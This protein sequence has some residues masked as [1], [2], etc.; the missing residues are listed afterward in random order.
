MAQCIKCKTTIPNGI[1]YCENCY[2]LVKNKA[3]ESYLDSLLSS[4]TPSDHAKD[5]YFKHKNQANENVA[6]EEQEDHVNN[7]KKEEIIGKPVPSDYNIFSTSDDDSDMDFLDSLFHSESEKQSQLDILHDVDKKAEDKKAEDKKAENKKAENKKAENKEAD[8]E[9]DK[10]NTEDEALADDSFDYSEILN[11]VEDSLPNIEVTRI[12]EEEAHEE[13]EEKKLEIDRFENDRL[14]NDSYENDNL[15]NM[16]LENKGQKEDL[17]IDALGYKDFDSNVQE[18]NKSEQEDHD[19]E[20]LVEGVLEE[21]NHEQA[22]IEDYDQ[23]NAMD[24]L[25][26]EILPLKDRLEEDNLKK[27]IKQAENNKEEEEPAM[28]ND[29]DYAENDQDL[30]DLINEINNSQELPS[31]DLIY[32]KNVDKKEEKKTSSMD[33]GDVFSDALGAVSS[34]GDVPIND[35]LLKMIPDIEERSTVNT[36][37]DI[38]PNKKKKEKNKQSK[39]AR[40]RVGFWK[41]IFG[42]IKEELTEEEIETRKN[43]VIQEGEQKEEKEKLKQ[44]ELKA[45]KQKEKEEKAE[46]EKQ[47]KELAAKKKAE[48]AAKAKAKKEEKEKRSREIQE[49]I[50]EI[51]ENEGKIN[52]VG[53]SIVF[54]FFAATAIVIVIGTN[55]YSY[56]VNIYNAKTSFERQLYNDAYQNVYGIDIKDEDLEIYDKIMTVMYVNKQL[57]SYNNFLNMKRYPEA[58]DS[59]LKGLDRYEKY[60]MLATLHGIEADLNYVKEH[61]VDELNKTFYLS[62]GEARE[63]LAFK[64][65]IEY[66]SEVYRLAQNHKESVP[67]MKNET[68][69]KNNSK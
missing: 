30:L 66:S 62:E 43:K 40:K 3:D 56:A 53:A 12:L 54:V 38:A 49:L 69:S 4:I 22:S 45:K 63:L 41:R 65:H 19:L 50:D 37:K 59:L 34:L 17:G 57:N 18:V 9:E 29:Y 58:L 67:D 51:D 13:A 31:E 55:L 23:D 35:E 25:L 47:A 8:K 61:I 27:D 60:Y 14:A 1:Q 33:I 28:K 44:E 39:E 21:E 15:G 6:L 52:K 24:E 36:A 26:S 68:D 64:D 16:N 32:D 11:I 7:S 2:S 20:S 10:K 5:I 46:K 48:N 42:N